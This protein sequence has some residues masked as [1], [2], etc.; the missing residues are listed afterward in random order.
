MESV[1]TQLHREWISLVRRPSMASELADACALA[2]ASSLIG[3]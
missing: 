2:G 3:S 1:F